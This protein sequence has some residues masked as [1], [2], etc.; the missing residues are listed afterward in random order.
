VDAV[1]AL[2]RGVNVGGRVRVPMAELRDVAAGLGLADV[3]TYVQSGNL[4]FRSPTGDA[5]G[6]TAALEARIAERFGH[7]VR[8]IARTVG[9]FA[10]AVAAN[11]FR[12]EAVDGTKVHVVFLESAPPADVVARL[13]PGRSPL[14]TFVV[15]GREL[16]VHYPDGAG[17]SKLTLD[18]VERVLEVA[19]T[20]RN[21]N[22]VTKLLAMAG[23]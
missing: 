17:R 16:Y 20:A 23:G 21:W 5:S 2:L 6:L 18:Y 11:P 1:I 19:A 7:P 3:R 8:V 15:L 13:D 9:E 22:T 10:E 14:D 4:V 12:D